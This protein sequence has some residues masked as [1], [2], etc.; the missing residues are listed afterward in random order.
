MFSTIS[1]VRI[2]TIL[3]KHYRLHLHASARRGCTTLRL[4]TH[5]FL[6]INTV[7]VHGTSKKKNPIPNTRS[8]PLLDKEKTHVVCIIHRVRFTTRASELNAMTKIKT[9]RYGGSH[10]FLVYDINNFQSQRHRREYCSSRR[11]FLNKITFLARFKPTATSDD[12]FID[13]KTV[14]RLENTRISQF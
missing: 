6:F 8:L 7:R 13:S 14:V 2:Q 5:A 1:S 12:L 10:F 3:Y 9:V 4:Y 11:K